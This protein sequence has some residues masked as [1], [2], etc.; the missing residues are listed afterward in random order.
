MSSVIFVNWRRIRKLIW[1][2]CRLGNWESAF[3]RL[4]FDWLV[5]F[6]ILRGILTY[7]WGRMMKWREL[8]ISTYFYKYFSIDFRILLK[9][10]WAS[11]VSNNFVRDQLNS[12]TY[13]LLMSKSSTSIAG[14]WTNTRS[15]QCETLMIGQN[16]DFYPNVRICSISCYFCHRFTLW[17]DLMN[18]RMHLPV[19]A[20]H[21]CSLQF[22]LH[23]TH[24]VPDL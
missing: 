3:L 16:S 2:L 11:H 23:F 5:G 17:Y 4:F 15:L 21:I 12:K 18:L 20:S 13:K 8:R 10:K 14:G 24:P 6:L 19:V 1:L 7:M 9:P 22:L